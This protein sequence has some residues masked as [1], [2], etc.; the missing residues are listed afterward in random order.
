[1]D[2][3]SEIRRIL[4][5]DNLPPKPFTEQNLIIGVPS[6]AD[7]GVEYNSSLPL[8]SVPGR[9]YYGQDTVFY[10]RIPLDTIDHSTPLRTTATLTRE[11][12]I[13]LLNKTFNLFLIDDDLEPFEIPVVAENSNGIVTIQSKATSLGFINGMTFTIEYGRAWLDVAVK[14]RVLT[15]LNHPDILDYRKS[16]RMLTWGIDFTSLRD[17][18]L[19]D[20]KTGTYTDTATFQAAC[21]AMGIPLWTASYITDSPTSSVPGANPVFDR[22]VIQRGISTGEMVGDLYFHYNNLEEI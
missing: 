16:C 8:D 15:E 20:P 7:G 22:V 18:M 2:S 9:G 10:K 12:I 6:A 11:S 14:N 3:A 13:E 1:M 5:E 17:S 21:A 4:N 19:R